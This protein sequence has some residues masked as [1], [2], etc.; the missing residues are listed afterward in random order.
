MIIILSGA[1][2]TGKTYQIERLSSK[3][4][5]R[6]TD[7]AARNCP[8]PINGKTDTAQ[9]WLFW[10]QL[11]TECEAK[12]PARDNDVVLLDR[13]VIDVFVY[14]EFYCMD[15]AFAKLFKKEQFT[16]VYER[17]YWFRTFEFYVDDGVRDK[18]EYQAPLDSIFAKYYENNPKVMQICNEDDVKK[19][20]D[21]IKGF[22]ED[23]S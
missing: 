19:M 17:I 16:P 23:L 4:E 8:Y 15:N 20:E 12:K 10:D 9:E 7:E 5:L 14:S 6:H 3:Y 22:V 18:K 21:E 11:S 13:C 1:H 2:G